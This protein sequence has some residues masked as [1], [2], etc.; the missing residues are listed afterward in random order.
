MAF[1]FLVKIGAD[2]TGFDTELGK[3]SAKIKA[4]GE[5][6][7]SAGVNLTASITAPLVGLA[8]AGSKA[9]ASFDDSLSKIVGLVG[10]SRDQ[11]NAWRDDI[12][13]LGPA[14]GKGPG[15]LAEAMFFV[16]S[17]GLRGQAAL[18]T[19][20]AAAKAASAG[21]GETSSVADA[22]TSA[23]NA[24]GI[25][26]L[27]AADAT[28]ILVAAVREGK[29]E[30][31]DLAPVLGRVIPI[32]SELGVGFDEV[33][34]SIAAMT[35]LGFSADESATSLSATLSA[36]LNPSKQ[37]EEALN[38]LGLSSEGLRRTMRE[39]GLLTALSEIRNVVGDNTAAL[40]EVIPNVRALR[41]VLALVGENAESTRQIF[42]SLAKA[43]VGDLNAAFAEA[44]RQVKFKF[45]QALASLQ[46]ALIRVGDVIKPVLIPILETLSVVLQRASDFF[47]A[48]P[49]PV[50]VL[51]LAV[52]ALAAALGPLLLI[53]GQVL[54]SVGVLAP[55]FAG[56]GAALAPLISGAGF[57]ALITV[58]TPIVPVVVAIGA[59]VFALKLAFDQ[60]E[61]SV[62][63]TGVTFEDFKRVFPTLSLFID[64]LINDFDLLVDAVIA[65]VA[66]IASGL[67]FLVRKFLEFTTFTAGF[68]PGIKNIRESALSFL[69]GIENTLSDFSKSLGDA[70]ESSERSFKKM[71]APALGPTPASPTAPTLTGGGGGFDAAA[72]EASKV[73]GELDKALQQV[74]NSAVVFGKSFDETGE[75]I[76]VV[77]AALK[78]LIESGV[79]PT[80]AS[81]QALSK[82][83]QTLRME[84]ET[85]LKDEKVIEIQKRLA[86][87]I[88]AVDLTSQA[89]G[90][91][92]DE[93][94]ART[95][96]M[97]AAINELAEVGTPAAISAMQMLGEQIIEQTDTLDLWLG[98]SVDTMTQFQELS[99][100]TF[101][102]FAS[103][104][105]DSVA[106]VIVFGESLAENLK[107][108]LKQIAANIISTLLQIVIKQAI[109]AALGTKLQKATALDS[110]FIASK[111]AAAAAFAGTLKLIPA[112]IGIPIALALGA[113]AGATTLALGAFAEG[114][115]ITEPTIGLIGEAGAEA[116]IP[117]DRLSEFQGSQTVVVELDG[118]VLTSV[119]VNKMPEMVRLEGIGR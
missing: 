75:R 65:S 34:A 28:G 59:A 33:S 90:S 37:A 12:L 109:I 45:N 41:G 38:A 115:V 61:K 78:K 54:I 4:S 32:A 42:A 74:G 18:D 68:I 97:T 58:L 14:V 106:G 57:P 113:L 10:V 89:L 110:V 39:E 27:N 69:E 96:A 29:A 6:L 53:L 40:G 31:A 50:K 102:Q 93:T 79:S 119:V 86:A 36:L 24:Y 2:L 99:R 72:Q 35:R 62:K 118:E 1:D 105:G 15:E 21:L 60:I 55:V 46:T 95:S 7:R 49:G 30:A 103:G 81:V 70:A 44:E 56:L 85:A 16:T 8:V 116:V 9:S 67:V 20:E 43:G 25:E 117:L 98:K 77:E 63:Q 64:G 88:Q 101:D 91:T 5:K 22:V 3:I 108:L 51:L 114:G 23:L 47:A 80:D 107:N 13:A 87:E 82:E 84:Q 17:A 52:A 112:P 92:F 100:S 19:L 73:L 111:E 26:N 76:Q 104:F 11:V 94:Q 48:L 66:D 83:L 71:Q